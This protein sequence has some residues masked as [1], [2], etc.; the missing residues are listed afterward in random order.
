MIVCAVV[1]VAGMVGLLVLIDRRLLAAQAAHERAFFRFGFSSLR[2]SG[3]RLSLG[4]AGVPLHS[5][6]SG[7]AQSFDAQGR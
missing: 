5:T 2:R 6:V 3:D 1:Y 4:A 7:P